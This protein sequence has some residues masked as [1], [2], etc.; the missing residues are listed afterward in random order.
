MKRRAPTS[1]RHT[2]P[3]LLFVASMRAHAQTSLSATWAQ[4][5]DGRVEVVVPTKQ[6]RKQCS[7][8]T[9]MMTS[10]PA[11]KRAQTLELSMMCAGEPHRL[12]LLLK[13]PIDRERVGVTRESSADFVVTLRKQKR[14]VWWSSL[15]KHPE[16]YGTLIQQHA[17]RGD[18]EPEGSAKRE[19]Y[20]LQG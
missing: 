8:E 9:A 10:D 3:L 5:L 19:L 2:S 13:H 17:T 12:S 18:A 16:K 11:D 4:Y 7:G 6:A 1:M 14:S 15:T 20:E